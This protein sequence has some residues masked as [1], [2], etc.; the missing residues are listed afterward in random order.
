MDRPRSG[1]GRLAARAARVDRSRALAAAV[2]VALAVLVPTGP[3]PAALVGPLALGA[4]LALL[5]SAVEV[6]RPYEKR[7]L[8]VLG[9]YR[10]LLG[11][12]LNLVPPLVSRTRTFDT[13]T[14]TLGVSE[15]EVLT[16]DD[17]PVTAD[18]VV[19]V[20]VADPERAHLAVEDHREAVS[21]LARS[22]LRAVLSDV[23]LD[24]A[25]NERAEIAARVRERLEEPTDEWGVRVERV[26][27]QRVMPASTVVEAMERETVAERRRRAKVLEARGERRSAIE[28]AEGER[29]ASVI[30]ARGEKQ[31]RILE[32]QA[33]VG[34]ALAAEDAD[35]ETG[36]SSS[37]RSRKPERSRE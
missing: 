36:R 2:A 14:R 16:R 12:G 8:T 22:A 1:V 29:A 28:R 9:E 7:A 27:V 35:S 11:P 13:R 15:Q 23:A 21:E 37:R 4:V 10:G 33:D 25:L 26:E 31:S 30:R 3:N 20:R 5:Y 24:D 18:A 32:A 34:E 6:V 17:A 19:Y